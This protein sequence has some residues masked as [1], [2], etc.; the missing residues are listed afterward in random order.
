MS[1]VS[2]VLM[3]LL[4][5]TLICD[6]EDIARDINCLTVRSSL[7]HGLGSKRISKNDFP[8]K[9]ISGKLLNYVKLLDCI[10]V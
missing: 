8:S 1:A 10:C 7:T 4:S 2:V 3:I 5:T 9:P 6:A